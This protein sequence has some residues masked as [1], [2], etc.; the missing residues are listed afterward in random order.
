MKRILKD[1]AR[2]MMILLGLMIL[3]LVVV[4][5]LNP[6]LEFIKILSLCWLA[7]KAMFMSVIVCLALFVVIVIVLFACH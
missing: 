7:M 2:I 3:L 1:V 6:N 5:V 4:R